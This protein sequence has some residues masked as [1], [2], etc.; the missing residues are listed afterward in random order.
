MKLNKKPL[1]Y[2][3]YFAYFTLRSWA[4]RSGMLFIR[5]LF[6]SVFTT[7]I[8]FLLFK[9][10]FFENQNRFLLNL[11][12]L[13]IRHFYS[14]RTLYNTCWITK[15]VIIYSGTGIFLVYWQIVIVVTK[16]YCFIS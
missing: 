4:P 2:V 8:T 14:L 10:E 7:L 5:H 13:I 16:T 6:L 9:C 11:L 15:C 3:F 12:I 1:G